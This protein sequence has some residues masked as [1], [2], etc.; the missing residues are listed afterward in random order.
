VFGLGIQPLS[1][2]VMTVVL[3]A[4]WRSLSRGLLDDTAEVE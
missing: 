3:G 1:V 4:L 2:V